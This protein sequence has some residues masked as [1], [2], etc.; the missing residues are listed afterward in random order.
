M[1]FLQEV[2]RRTMDSIQTNKNVREPE[3]EMR[4]PA[5]VAP[6]K[7]WRL[8]NTLLGSSRGISSLVGTPRRSVDREQQQYAPIYD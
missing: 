2:A 6:S 5:R 7:L 8:I 1:V 3:M 4:L